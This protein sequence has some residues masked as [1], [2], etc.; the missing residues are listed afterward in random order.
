[1]LTVRPKETVSMVTRDGVRLDADVYRPD[2]T[3]DLPVLLMRQ[4]YGRAIA[5]TVVYAHPIWYA[6][7][8]YIVV[9]QDVRGRGSSEGEFSLFAHEIEDGEDTVNWAA[10]L[11]G[12]TGQV[13]MYGFSYQGMTQ[14]YAAANKPIALKTICPSMIGYDLYA[15]WAYEGGAFCYQLNLGWAIQLAAETARRQGNVEAY[16]RLYAASR[17]V[18][19]H[20]PV[21]AQSELLKELAPDSFYHDWVTHP[22]PDDYW[23]QLSPCRYMQAVDMPMLHIGGW[24]DTYMRG[25]LHFYQEMADRSAFPQHLWVGPWAHLPWGRKV[26]AIDYGTEA[27]NPIDRLQIRWFDQFLKGI[28]TGLLAEPPIH[29]FEMGSH[30]WRSFDRYPTNHAKSYYLV[31]TGLAAMGDREGFLVERTEPQSPLNPS[32]SFVDV[33]VHD[34]WR[35]MPSVGGH[36]TMPAGSFERGAI[37]CRTDGVTYTS[38]P[39]SDPLHLVGSVK[40][41]I[42]C[43]ADAISFD[44]CAVVSEVKPNGS[45]F[46]I[47]QG[48]LRV[49]ADESGSIV[50]MG[51]RNDPTPHASPAAQ[52]VHITLQPTCIQIPAGSAIRLTLSGACFPAYAVN[53][54]DGS[55]PHQAQ[56]INAKVITIGI[57]C[58]GSN[59]TTEGD[60]TASHRPSR[61]LLPVIPPVK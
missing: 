9:I 35:P 52:W 59:P 54:G 4:P 49:E 31:T 19:I 29:L 40:V 8:G 28:D 61:L 12:S 7:H 39:L 44:L 47:S 30:Q 26:G 10:N 34:P 43:M 5:S 48:Y 20:D 27:S 42:D 17:N 60:R 25:T 11:P 16:Q 33:F 32:Q 55:Y 18:A 58:E 6:A 1:M 15:D 2:T 53:P 50:F 23:D 38:A 46:N 24:F 21:C 36:A 14:L 41:E 56:L 57:V 51:D 37:D 3:D 22:K 13:G 45:V